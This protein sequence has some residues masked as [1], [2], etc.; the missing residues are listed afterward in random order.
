MCLIVTGAS[1]AQESDG[2]QQQSPYADWYQVEVLIFANRLAPQDDE[3]W[4]LATLEY[5]PDMVA[6]SPHHDED[7]KPH[8]LAQLDDLMASGMQAPADD[9]PQTSDDDFMFENRS[10][11]E[12]DPLL[13][14]QAATTTDETAVTSLDPEALAALFPD[15][16]PEAFR[17]PARQALNL[18]S[19]ARSLNRSSRYRLLEHL[20]W[21]QPLDAV[22]LPVLVQAGER[23]G[24]FFEIDGT[25]T[26]SRSRYLHVDTN[27]WFTEFT[28]RYEGAG[29]T[30]ET[31]LPTDLPRQILDR[32]PQLVAWAK[33]RETHLPLHMHEM[34]QSR[35]MRGGEVH[36]LD[37]PFFGVII[38]VDEFSYE[39]E[40]AVEDAES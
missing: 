8:S 17:M 14:Q 33:Q 31:S 25:L 9:A 11:F 26:I 27:L 30:T 16:L 15:D 35:R 38:R 21:R 22:T 20:A 4:P 24:D 13:R 39:P 1:A 36:Y 6:V 29:V 10:R 18:Q 23:Y 34:R 5:P 32:Y 40:G 7:I 2:N 12:Q 37:H 19:V 28:P 3:L